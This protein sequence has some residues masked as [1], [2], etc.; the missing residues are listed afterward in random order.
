[1]KEDVLSEVTPD[2]GAVPPE[3]AL[4]GEGDS[5]Q[6]TNA[7]FISAIFLGL[8]D[9]V[10]PA[11]CSKAGDPEKGA[12]FAQRADSVILSTENNNY[13]ALST[14]RPCDDDSFKVRK[15]Q[16]VACYGLM[17]DDLGT[18]APF[19]QLGDFQPSCLIETSPGNHQALILFKEPV[20][21]L[22][23]LEKF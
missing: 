11:V 19:E 10:S 12:W 7:E 17:L 2:Q 21:D 5:P 15:D 18:K 4:T 13:L 20:T 14:F 3:A 6:V 1:M 22:A 16:V 8:P 23:L 9:G